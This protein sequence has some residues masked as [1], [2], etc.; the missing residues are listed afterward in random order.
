[1]LQKIKNPIS[2]PYFHFKKVTRCLCRIS[3]EW[4]KIV[5][6]CVIMVFLYH[7]MYM[8]DAWKKNPNNKMIFYISSGQ[9]NQLN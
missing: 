2:V 8:H 3:D 5:F 1:M 7:V 4:L 9:H 6:A